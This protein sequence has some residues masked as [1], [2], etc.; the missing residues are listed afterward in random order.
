MDIEKVRK[1]LEITNEYKKTDFWTAVLEGKFPNNMK[2]SSDSWPKYDVY[3]NQYYNYIIFEVPGVRREH[4]SIH[5]LANAQLKIS[6]V[7]H[8]VIQFEKEIVRE[9]MYGQFERI[10]D[11]PE[12]TDTNLIN[13]Q[14]SDG[15]L[16][17]S[18]PRVEQPLHF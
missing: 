10:I 11:L 8:P 2:K 18:Y 4:L 1:W 17:I 13:I 16:L 5:L 9:R 15:L 12:V 7:L 6:G 14:M 3:Q